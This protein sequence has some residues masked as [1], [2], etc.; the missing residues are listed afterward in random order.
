MPHALVELGACAG[1]SEGYRR[2]LCCEEQ[3]K[4]T[5]HQQSTRN[6]F[7]TVL[8]LSCCFPVDKQFVVSAVHVLG[9]FLSSPTL[10]ESYCKCLLLR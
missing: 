7:S 4:E 8:L 3:E 9:I 2:G 10:T 1:F 6:N 5:M